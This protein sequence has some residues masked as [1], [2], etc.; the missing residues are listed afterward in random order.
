MEKELRQV[1]RW[2]LAANGFLLILLIA[3]SLLKLPLSPFYFL[4]LMLA[5][6]I[7]ITLLWVDFIAAVGD[8]QSL[9]LPFP[10]SRLNAVLQPWLAKL[11][12]RGILHH[13]YGQL[14]LAGLILFLA[15]SSNGFF[16]LS[17]LFF[18]LAD[19]LIE[20]TFLSRQQWY[21]QILQRQLK[22]AFPAVRFFSGIDAILWLF[23]FI[24]IIEW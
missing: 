20:I 22:P 16:V 21:R 17:C 7:S 11:D 12:F 10:I 15:T 18:L 24:K 23:L 2:Q 13:I 4:G 3:G 6:V 1:W 19:L 8:S 9:L 5:A 14:T